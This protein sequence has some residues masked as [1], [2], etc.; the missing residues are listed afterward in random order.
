[1]D[2]KGNGVGAL[3]VL[4]G[5]GDVGVVEHLSLRD[6]P[7]RP[8]FEQHPITDLP[9]RG[10]LRFCLKSQ[11]PHGSVLLRFLLRLFAFDVTFHQLPHRVLVYFP[12]SIWEHF[13]AES[14]YLLD[15]VLPFL[16]LV[17]LEQVVGDSLV[18][19]QH[20]L[21]Q[22]LLVDELNLI[23]RVLLRLHEFLFRAVV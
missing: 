2:K 6:L 11:P 8:P 19:I 18:G 15:G 1:M 14:Q 9:N 16:F 17:E 12:V 3:V 5:F 21:G 10:G 20:R 22:Y 23:F 4:F 13:L 7:R